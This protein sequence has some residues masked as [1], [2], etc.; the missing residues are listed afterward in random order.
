MLSDRIGKGSGMLYVD[1]TGFVK[2][3]KY[4]VGIKREYCGRLGKTENCQCGVL[5]AYAGTVGYGPVDY[6]LYITCEW[7][8]GEFSQLRKQ[9]HIPEAPIFLTKNEIAMDMLNKILSN[10]MF[11]VIVACIT[12][13]IFFKDVIAY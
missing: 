3:G 7:F 2:K 10:G 11:Q 1:D 4:S 9:C 13:K 12:I 5:L 6:E 8:S